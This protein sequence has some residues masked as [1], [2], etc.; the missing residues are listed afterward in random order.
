MSR[1]R[2]IKFLSVLAAASLIVAACGDDDDDD[3][4]VTEET[5]EETSAGTEA[6]GTTAGTE[7]EAPARGTDRAGRGPSRRAP[8]APAPRTSASRAAA[9]AA[10]PTAR[11]RTPGEAPTGEVR[12]A[13]NQAPYSFNT[14]R[15]GRQR[16]RQRQPASDG[17]RQHGCG[18][19]YYD[20]D[21]NFINNDQF[22]TCTVESLDPL[23]VTY[24]I[25]EGVTWSDG[26]PIDA[27][28]LILQWAAQSGV[29]NDANTVVTADRRDRR[30]RR[31]RLA[32]RPRSRTAPITSVDEADRSRLRPGDGALLEGYTLQGVD[33]RHLRRRQ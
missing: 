2:S 21:L 4:A 10:S 18:F 24:T 32:H 30:G 16:H 1:R 7:A 14:T 9:G 31:G 11:T 28:D 25:N 13:W 33:R 19:A 29:F 3:D 15:T 8:G 5:T 22:G 20:Q 27:A 17:H 12:V 23:T 6:G 26:T